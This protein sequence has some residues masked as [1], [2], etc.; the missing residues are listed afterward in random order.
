MK[1]FKLKSFLVLMLVLLI[2]SAFSL[3]K[4]TIY[5][6]NGE[7][8]EC[9]VEKY[10]IGKYAEVIDEYNNKRIITWDFIK[11]I[12]F[13]KATAP[14]VEETPVTI[15]KEESKSMMDDFEYKKDIKS[16]KEEVF[17]KDIQDENAGN[18]PTIDLD[19]KTGEISVDY[20]QT[21]ESDA[22]RRCWL[23]DGGILKS[24]SMTLNYTHASM[25]MN[26]DEFTMNGF[27]FSM[28]GA[29]KF[30]NPP[31]Y[32]EGKNSWN[33][34]SMGLMCTYSM[35]NGEMATIG[36][37][38]RTFEFSTNVGYT[39]GIGKFWSESDWKGIMLGLYWKPNFTM[40]RSTMEM[41]GNYYEGD[42]TSIF[43]AMGIQWTIDWGDF[44]ALVDNLAQEAH[45]SISGFILPETDETPFLISIGI[46]AVWY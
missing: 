38:N 34:F 18:Q 7:I 26:G 15:K 24:K 21:L 3:E 43:N 1:K 27:G 8:L 19:K 25:D 5:Y 12:V 28:L 41:G 35:T 2:S 23:E 9:H 44:G 29:L 31:N 11:E 45:L 10:E 20:Y 36:I 13:T 22:K 32:S 14:I 37:V 46:G 6:K 4:A 17:I 42:P 16:P 40:S 39:Y 33:A 30:L